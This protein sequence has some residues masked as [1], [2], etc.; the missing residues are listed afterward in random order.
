MADGRCRV[1][2]E[3]VSPEIDCG[4]F[5]IKRVTGEQVVVE[6]DIF[7]DG[8]DEVSAVLCYRR[9]GE[10][11]WIEV[12]MAPLV[13]DRWRASFPVS[14][15]GLYEYTIVAWVDRFRTWEHDLE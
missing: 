5:A 10:E 7:T 6:A 11:G 2:I 1:V 15:L 8:H 14:D 3:G 12:E 9:G 13:N 4:R